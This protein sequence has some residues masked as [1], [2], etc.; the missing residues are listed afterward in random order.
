VIDDKQILNVRKTKSKVE[1][2]FRMSSLFSTTV[3]LKPQNQTEILK[4][5]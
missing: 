1:S 2:L 3:P 5:K 4:N